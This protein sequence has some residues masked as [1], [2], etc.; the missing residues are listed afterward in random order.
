MHTFPRPD[1]FNIKLTVTDNDGT[2]ASI[3]R[4]FRVYEGDGPGPGPGPGP[5][6]PGTHAQVL[7]VTE[8]LFSELY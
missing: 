8:G 6:G 4:N 5:A 2:I 3:N 1:T 7:Q